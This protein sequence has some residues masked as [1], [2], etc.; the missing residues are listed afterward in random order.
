M[1]PPLF[2][3]YDPTTLEEALV[4]LRANG[5][6]AK[7]LAG[8]QSL[9]PMLNMRLLHPATIVDINRIEAL[10][11]Y[12]SSAGGMRIGALTRHSRLEDDA[13]LGANQP[14]MATALPFIAHRAIR[15]RGTIGGSLSH[16]DPAA[17]WGALALALEVELVAQRADQ[18]ARVI[19]ANDFHRGLLSTALEPDEL[20]L[21]IRAPAW[22]ARR[23][24]SFREFSRRHGDFALAGVAATLELD[25]AGNCR[26]ARIALIG[27]GDRPVRAAA[28]ERALHNAPAGPTAFNAAAE[29]AGQEIDPLDDPH[30][31]ANYRRRLAAVLVED[32]LAEASQRAQHES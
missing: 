21:E 10:S 2:D 4:L 6:D 9:G 1:K 16:A 29:A 27:V 26:E 20:L 12:E 7:V 14:L 28:A 17:E 18:P 30:A 31:S 19:A 11:H 32:A 15:N 3:Y 22:P 5:D 8:S 13:S 24:W 23:G 25:A